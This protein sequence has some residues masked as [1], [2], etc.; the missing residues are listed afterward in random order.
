[1]LECLERDMH[2]VL[3]IYVIKPSVVCFNEHATK[4]FI[5]RLCN[6]APSIVLSARSCVL[7]RISKCLWSGAT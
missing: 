2:A 7:C 5:L 4:P 1:M 6:A 3:C